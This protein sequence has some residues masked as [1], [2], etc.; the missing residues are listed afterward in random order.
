MPEQVIVT[1]RNPAPGVVGDAGQVTY[2]YYVVEGDRLTMTDST[3]KV[4]RRRS[5]GEPYTHK[6]E[7]GEDPRRVAGRLTKRIREML[8]GD[9]LGGFH[10]RLTYP[11]AGVA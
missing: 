8:H 9:D 4:I 3:G 7:P 2:G 5:N 1:I 6:L 11:S 10:R